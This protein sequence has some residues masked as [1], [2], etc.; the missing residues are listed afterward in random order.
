MTNYASHAAD[1]GFGP[2]AVPLTF[3]R[4]ASG[5]ISGPHT[6][7]VKPAHVRLLDYEVEIGLVLGREIPV[8]AEIG[9]DILAEYV[10]GMV[11]TNDVSVRDVHCPRP[12]STSRSPTPPSP[13]SG[14]PWCCWTTVTTTPTAAAPCPLSPRPVY[15]A[16]PLGQP[17][18][19]PGADRDKDGQRTKSSREIG[20]LRHVRLWVQQGY[21]E[22]SPRWANV[23]R[24]DPSRVQEPGVKGTYDY[25]QAAAEAAG[26][27]QRSPGRVSR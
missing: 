3:F 17:S 8:D 5:S 11:V 24:H 10:A 13:R 27:M 25:D 15:R 9:E 21:R 14:P 18:P 22:V 4:K 7:I 23:G 2:K 26:I 6:D 12:S 16:L 19:V 20:R 1:A